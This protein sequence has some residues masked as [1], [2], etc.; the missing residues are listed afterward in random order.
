MLHKSG[1]FSKEQDGNLES[2]MKTDQKERRPREQEEGPVR[3][4]GGAGRGELERKAIWLQPSQVFLHISVFSDPSL[5]RHSVVC[6]TDSGL[7]SLLG[8]A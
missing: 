1:G 7:S 6:R 8:R 5:S 3:A 2:I 4:G